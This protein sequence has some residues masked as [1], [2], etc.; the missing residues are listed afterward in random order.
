MMRLPHSPAISLSAIIPSA[1]GLV[2]DLLSR[3]LVFNPDKRA[4]V[5]ECLAHPYLTRVRAA[6]RSISEGPPPLQR[7]RI[8]VTGGAAALK[9]LSVAALR[10]RFFAEVC[11][12]VGS[13]SDALMMKNIRVAATSNVSAVSLPQSLS[14]KTVIPGPVPTTVASVIAPRSPQ[15]K[16][17]NIFRHSSSLRSNSNSGSSSSGDE[18]VDNKKVGKN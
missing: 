7:L 4:T 5:E 11:G 8:R 16:L 1:Q 2:L 12:I 3:M 17:V 10:S 6:R 9:A 14:Q 15:D 13:G 18:D